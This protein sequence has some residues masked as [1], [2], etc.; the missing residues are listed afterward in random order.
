M[1]EALTPEEF[2]R[3]R[4]LKAREALAAERQ[5]GAE[6]EVRL[7]GAVR[8]MAATTASAVEE[9]KEHTVHEL[10]GIRTEIRNF[11]MEAGTVRGAAGDVDDWG[12]QLGSTPEGSSF[13]AE[14]RAK[15]DDEPQHE[16]DS[17]E[18]TAIAAGG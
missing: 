8:H 12:V 6:R 17:A 9:R 10:N 3:L 4:W 2:Y 7:L 11:L 13:H 5:A 15:P 1:N 16:E 14:T 18:G